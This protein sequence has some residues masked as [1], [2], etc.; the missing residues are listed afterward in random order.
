MIHAPNHC[1]ENSTI[2]PF[3]GK[4]TTMLQAHTLTVHCRLCMNKKN[5]AYCFNALYFNVANFAKYCSMC[6][7]VGTEHLQ[8]F[9]QAK[10][11]QNLC[12]YIMLTYTINNNS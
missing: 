3:F 2:S 7:I 8:E 12:V 1:K 4:Y 10:N 11:T 9:H 5:T 6:Y